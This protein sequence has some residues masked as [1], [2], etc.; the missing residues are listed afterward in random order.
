MY[1]GVSSGTVSGWS[2]PPRYRAVPVSVTGAVIVDG[3]HATSAAATAG[4]ASA[5][6]RLV[7]RMDPP[8]LHSGITNVP[9][10]KALRNSEG[11]GSSGLLR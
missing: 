9:A 2:V 8:L 5:T 7:W 6:D 10:K 4:K 3:M 1:S 11:S